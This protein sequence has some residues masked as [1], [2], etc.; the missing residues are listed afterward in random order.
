MNEQFDNMGELYEY[1]GITHGVIQAF[2]KRGW[3]L[4]YVGRGPMMFATASQV[5]EIVSWGRTEDVLEIGGRY[6]PLPLIED[7]KDTFQM[8]RAVEEMVRQIRG[9][10]YV[11]LKM[12][13]E[14]IE[15]VSRHLID[16]ISLEPPFLDLHC[17]VRFQ[18]V[19]T[20]NTIELHLAQ[21]ADKIC[22]QVL[23]SLRGPEVKS[24]D[25]PV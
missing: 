7:S 19:T 16:S 13:G 9:P 6:I 22:V 20:E 15:I 17:D 24:A 18:Q 8:M 10:Y 4:Y 23:M 1:I 3:G 21:A 14:E 25:L 2:E 11:E 12:D 5:M